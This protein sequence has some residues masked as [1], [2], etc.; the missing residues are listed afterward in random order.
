MKLAYRCR[1]LLGEVYKHDGLE[2]RIIGR[3]SPS[4]WAD[5]VKKYGRNGRNFPSE[6]I[7]RRDFRFLVNIL[8]EM[9][10]V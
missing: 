6:E 5:I 1:K 4:Q 2:R 9:G 3:I 10:L 7:A 8:G